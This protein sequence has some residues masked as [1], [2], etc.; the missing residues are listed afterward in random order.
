MSQLV[1]LVLVVTLLSAFIKKIWTK[2]QRHVTAKRPITH[3]SRF[4]RPQKSSGSGGGSQQL[5]EKVVGIR[6]LTLDS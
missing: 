6:V 1:L 2:K 3:G 4:Y 5:V